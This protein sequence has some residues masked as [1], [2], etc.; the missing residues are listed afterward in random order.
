MC[1]FVRIKF[2]GISIKKSNHNRGGSHAVS[3]LWRTGCLFDGQSSNYLDILRG[4]KSVRR[5]TMGYTHP[6]KSVSGSLTFQPQSLVA[7]ISRCNIIKLLE[8]PKA[9][10]YQVLPEKVTWPRT[11]SG[12]VKR[13][14]INL[15][16]RRLAKWTISSQVLILPSGA[17]H[18]VQRLNGDG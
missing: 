13:S 4:L 3:R 2:Y 8:H 14:A 1:V 6:T 18:A 5:V 10:D 12:K 9:S 11:T 17:T 15:S 7:V 16:P